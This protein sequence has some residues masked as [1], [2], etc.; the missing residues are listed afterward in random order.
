[1]FSVS[2]M[3]R[4]ARESHRLEPW[5]DVN[6]Q[7]SSRRKPTALLPRSAPL[8]TPAIL[9]IAYKNFA[10][11]KAI[12]HIGL[13][14]AALSNAK[15]L[16]HAGIEVNVWPINA[17]AELEANLSAQPV[18][19]VV[20]SAPWLATADLQ[21]LAIQHPNVR[22]ALNVHS[23]VAFLGADLRGVTLIREALALS[24]GVWNFHVAA[25]SE[26]GARWLEHAYRI[27]VR[28]LPN[29]YFLDDILE[30]RHHRSLW[31]HGET[32]RVGIF[33]AIRPLKNVVTGAA[34]VLELASALKVKVE[35][36]LSS[37]RSEG[38]GLALR[39]VIGELY[40]ELPYA[41]VVDD[42]WAAW[43]AFRQTVGHM[44]LLIQM[45][46]T[47][48]FNMVTADGIAEGVPSVVSEAIDW[49]P[50]HWRAPM[51]D[52]FEV[53]RVG[54]YLLG[55]LYALSEGLRALKAH[56]ASGLVSWKSFLAGG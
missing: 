43:P 5:E 49:V 2:G 4:Q 46:T 14:V 24:R 6:R 9:A 29:M 33:G 40:R 31:T 54:R 17:A 3:R 27:P 38:G 41:Q 8:N 16:R 39:Q 22:F 56:N 35:L 11:N 7:K 30:D 45:S 15:T 48:S 1:V 36:H 53:A 37:G 21:R 32:L 13:G 10:A 20:I 19:H 18:T 28:R 42:P 23:N 12:S 52:A 55:D 44:H 51:D 26:K 34:A 25:N 47:E 50:T